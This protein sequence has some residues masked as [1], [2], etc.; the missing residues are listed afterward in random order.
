MAFLLTSFHKGAQICTPWGW[1]VGLIILAHELPLLCSDKMGA[2]ACLARE[3]TLPSTVRAVNL[4]YLSAERDE[5]QLW[6][7][8]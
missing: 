2:M 3:P 4:F 7:L 5:S 8:L 6:S 1:T